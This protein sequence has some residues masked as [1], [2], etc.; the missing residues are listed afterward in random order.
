MESAVT[1]FLSQLGRSDCRID[2]SGGSADAPVLADRHAMTLVL[3]NLLDNAVKYSGGGSVRLRCDT[4]PGIL[5]DDQQRIFQKF[6]RGASAAATN[7]K[8]T[9][10]GLALVKLIVSGHGGEVRVNSQPDA[11]STFTVVLP[12]QG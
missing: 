8:G 10:L 12:A 1:E 11:G 2:V 5:P 3:H 4:G 9:G 7:V 6:V